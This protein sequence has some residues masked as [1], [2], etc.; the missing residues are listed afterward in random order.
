MTTIRR[1]VYT[2][3]AA[4]C[5]T[6]AL[7]AYTPVAELQINN[8]RY[9]AFGYGDIDYVPGYARARRC[10]RTMTTGERDDGSRKAGRTLQLETS[11]ISRPAVLSRPL[12]FDDPIAKKLS[13]QLPFGPNRYAYPAIRILLAR[14][15]RLA[16]TRIPNRM[17]EDLHRPARNPG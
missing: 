14:H 9:K 8:S 6:A 12:V 15:D 16:C 13:F 5:I 7:C 10:P 1:C 4:R 11:R 17:L 2:Q 3:T